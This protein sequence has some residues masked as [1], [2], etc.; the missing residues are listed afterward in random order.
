M[1]QLITKSDSSILLA[2]GRERIIE[3]ACLVAGVHHEHRGIQLDPFVRAN[4]DGLVGRVVG[5]CLPQDVL[6]FIAADDLA[7]DE[8]LALMID[9]HEQLA[10]LAI[11]G[12]A[13]LAAGSITS[14]SR[15]SD[16][17]RV[18][19]RKQQQLEDDVDQ[20]RQVEDVERRAFSDFDCHA[21]SIS[22][23]PAF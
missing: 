12:L 16:A 10:R 21:E 7:L 2:G 18:T 1:S 13:S 14:N 19:T 3:N 22:R 4:D 11:S 6:D 8:V 20:R 17:K 15:S 23:S 5:G 9:V